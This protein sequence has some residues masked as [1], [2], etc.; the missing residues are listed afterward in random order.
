MYSLVYKYC[1]KFISANAGSPAGP[2]FPGGPVDPAPPMGPGFPEG[3]GLPIG[4]GGPCEPV[5]PWRNKGLVM[6]G[7]QAH[8]GQLRTCA[9]Y[10]H[11]TSFLPI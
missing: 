6:Q 2:G 4:P 9:D 3:P 8:R 7:E 1:E 5:A 10:S 11:G